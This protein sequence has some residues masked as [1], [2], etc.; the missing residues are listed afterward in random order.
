MIKRFLKD[1]FWGR[2]DFLVFGKFFISND[3]VIV[4]LSSN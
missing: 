3:E 1:A 2:L 4:I